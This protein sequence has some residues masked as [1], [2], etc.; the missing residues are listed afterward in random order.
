MT[1]KHYFPDVDAY[2]SDCA[3]SDK[4]I[5]VQMIL[6]RTYYTNAG[7]SIPLASVIGIVRTYDYVC[8]N[9]HQKYKSYTGKLIRCTT[10][11]RHNNRKAGAAVSR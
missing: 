4:H 8:N 9:L 7:V 1:S 5:Y 11:S 3:N 2:V 6:L 10:P